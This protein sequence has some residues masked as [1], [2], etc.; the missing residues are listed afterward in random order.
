MQMGLVAIKFMFIF[1]IALERIYELLL[2]KRNAAK[3]F[4]LGGVEHGKSHFPYMVVLHL[5]FFMAIPIE[6]FW[7]DQVFRIEL[8]VLMGVISALSM[9]LRYWAISSLGIFWNTRVIVLPGHKAIVKGPFQWV[10][11]P[12][13]VA[14][15]V[16]MAAIPLFYGAWRTAILYSILN[17]WML[18]IRISVEENALKQHCSY[19]GNFSGKNAFVP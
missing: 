11:H 13:Y 7:F 15:I 14:V 10:R 19:D 9:G 4:A 16:E 5:T 18:K 2:S 6:L 17:L 8:A 3:V 1:L 12:N